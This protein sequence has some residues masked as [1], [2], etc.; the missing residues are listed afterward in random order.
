[1]TV[2]KDILL[3]EEQVLANLQYSGINISI[4]IITKVFEKGDNNYISSFHE[5]R[6]R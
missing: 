5:Y 6:K 2:R 3:E 4:Q 1:M